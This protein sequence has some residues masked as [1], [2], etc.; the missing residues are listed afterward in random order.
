MLRSKKKKNEQKGGRNRSE[1]NK[2][3]VKTFP[4]NF[5]FN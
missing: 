5:I 1:F 4:R 3:K 2:K